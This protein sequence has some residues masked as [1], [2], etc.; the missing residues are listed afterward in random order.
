MDSD[1]GIDLHEIFD[2]IDSAEVLIV[3]F[4]IIDRRLLV[5]ARVSETEGPL[6]KVVPRA[7]SVEDRFRSLKRLRPRFPLP[8]KIMSFTWPRHVETLQAAGV[9]EHIVARLRAIGGEGVEE[10]CASAWQELCQEER[11]QVM[12]A[13]RGGEGYQSLW[14]RPR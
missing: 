10:Q 7:T 11:K 14:E 12:A 8:E 1:F 4:A 13:I 9:W 3:R 5:D 6:I 2:V